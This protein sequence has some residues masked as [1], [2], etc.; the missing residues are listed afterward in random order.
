MSSREKARKGTISQKKRHGRQSASACQG[1]EKVVSKIRAD[2]RA[3]VE[4]AVGG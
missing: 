2:V 1:E 3:R 4:G